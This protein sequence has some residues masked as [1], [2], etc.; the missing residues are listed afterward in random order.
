MAKELGI[1]GTQLK[2][3]RLEIE[4]F[5]SMEAKRRQKADAAEMERLAEENEILQMGEQAN[6]TG[7]RAPANAF[8]AARAVK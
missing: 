5:G 8:F 7:P 6:A 2:T 1:T 3:W 4:A